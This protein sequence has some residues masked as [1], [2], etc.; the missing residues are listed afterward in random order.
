MVGQGL[1]V[2]A[3]EDS[4]Q[5]PGQGHLLTSEVSPGHRQGDISLELKC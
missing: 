5:C 1:K 4:T 2:G 3:L